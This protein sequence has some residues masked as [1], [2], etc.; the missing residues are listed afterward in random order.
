MAGSWEALYHADDTWYPGSSSVAA[1]SIR[2][3]DHLPGQNARHCSRLT[4]RSAA[5]WRPSMIRNGSRVVAP[6]CAA[7]EW[8]LVAAAPAAGLQGM[9]AR[10]RD[11]AGSATGTAATGRQ[12]LAGSDWQAATAW[13]VTARE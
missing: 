7:G 8:P 5:P 11:L 13:G 12:R 3:R 6:S 2:L 4:R 1:K 10:E 9:T